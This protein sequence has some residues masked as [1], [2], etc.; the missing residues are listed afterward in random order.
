MQSRFE[1]LARNGRRLARLQ[2]A[3]AD[4]GIG[5]VQADGEEPIAAIEDDGQ[6]SG[7]ALM[8]LL[9]NRLIV[10]PRMALPKLPLRL[11]A[12]MQRNALLGRRGT[13]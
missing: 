4:R 7:L 11:R 13:R 6:V 12:D 3:H 9:A 8:A 1:P 2:D 10:E 5:I